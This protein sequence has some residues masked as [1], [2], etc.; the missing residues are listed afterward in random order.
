MVQLFLTGCGVYLIGHYLINR[1][2]FR[3]FRY[4]TNV[5]LF[6]TGCGFNNSRHLPNVKESSSTLLQYKLTAPDSKKFVPIV[7]NPN[8]DITFGMVDRFRV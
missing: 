7:Y 8:Y 3:N 4:L 1:F 5:I 6:L 2:G